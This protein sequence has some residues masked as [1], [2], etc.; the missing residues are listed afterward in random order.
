[1]T[2][3]LGVG[4]IWV[5]EQRDVVARAEVQSLW[6]RARA[7]V[8]AG[9]VEEA[10]LVVRQAAEA[11]Y[12]GAPVEAVVAAAEGVRASTMTGPRPRPCRCSTMCNWGR[13]MPK[14]GWPWPRR[15]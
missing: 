3:A 4:G 2:A 1:M 12:Q 7:R 15:S 10:R 14:P 9:S 13:A 6:E 5:N 8:P 11:V